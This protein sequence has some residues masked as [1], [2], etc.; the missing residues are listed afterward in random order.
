MNESSR[1]PAPGMA[2]RPSTAA[3]DSSNRRL[4]LHGIVIALCIVA[5]GIISFTRGQDINFDQLN[6]HF[7]SAYAYATDRLSQDVAPAQVMHSYFSPI[8]YLP[9]YYMVQHLPPPVVGIVL[10]SV[11]GLNFW[12]V[13][14]IGSIVTRT[15]A[16][17]IRLVTTIAAVA[18][19]AA[20]PMMASE[21]GTSMAD[22]VASLPILAGLALL[23]QAEF[24]GRRA[25]RAIATILLGGAFMGAAVS[26]K[27]TSAS[28]AVGL[29][30]AA[31]V[32][33]NRWRHRLI[34]V[35]ATGVGGVVGFAVIGGSWYLTMW[36][37][38][39]NPVFPYFN[40]VFRSPDYPSVTPLFD[41][42][43]IPHSLLEAASYPF[44][45]THLQQSTTEIQFRDIRFTVLIM[46]GAI[47]LALWLARRG[48]EPGTTTP[49][50]RRLIVFFAA[51]FCVWI[52]EWSIQRYIVALEL[53][54]GPA[55]I[56]LLQWSGL[57]AVARGRAVAATSVLLALA[58]IV[59]VRP[60]DWGHLGWRQTWYA[61][62]VPP[63]NEEHAVYFIDGSPLSFIVPALPPASPVIG[64]INW[65]N[66]PAWGNTVFTRRIHDILADPANK[67]IWAI[68]SGPLSDDFK[69]RIAL[70]G[71]KADGACETTKGRPW[72]VTWCVLSRTAPS[73]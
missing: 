21:F 22:L 10:G 41:L 57:F 19:S 25:G 48:R 38:F 47:A 2:T 67:Q 15:L 71:L 56:V 7:Y 64:V 24:D 20:A 39:R 68:A 16:P 29:A 61:I 40:T 52:Y 50:G 23:M 58:C 14:V 1:S 51:A 33:W 69:N 3:A 43:Y 73:G 17:A 49:A 4:V 42:H 54:A 5:G 18:I 13:F 9:F 37:L 53:L 27:L 59:S 11:H 36:R 55:T 34:A 12:L 30:F 70:Y 28:F 6:Y 32:G 62:E 8:V 60:I 35:V 66:V 46:L 31:L 45:W 26:L 72:P 65:E 44:L 63:T